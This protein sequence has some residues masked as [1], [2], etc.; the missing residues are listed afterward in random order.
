MNEADNVTIASG[1]GS[2]AKATAG[3]GYGKKDTK[4]VIIVQRYDLKVAIDEDNLDR[5]KA[6]LD[7]LVA[8]ISPGA[9]ARARPGEIRG[10][11]SIE[12]DDAAR[13]ARSTAPRR[14]SL[15]CSTA[16]SSTSSTARARP[17]RRADIEKACDQVLDDR[18]AEV[19]ATSSSSRR[20]ASATAG[21]RR[22]A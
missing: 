21:R 9:P 13:S 15:P 19:A 20:R 18:R 11:P 2:S 17:K 14:V 10:F 6:E 16:T 3:V 5:A 22:A 7:P 1:A 8:Q 4:D 12:Y